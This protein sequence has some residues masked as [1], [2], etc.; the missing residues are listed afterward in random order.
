VNGE[1]RADDTAS[2]EEVG[3][4]RDELLDQLLDERA[5]LRALHE[6]AHSMDYG[7]EVGWVNAFS[8]DAVF[9]VF[10]AVEGTLIHR[11]E[12]H[13]DLAKYVAN[14]PKPPRFRKHIVVDPLI[15]VRGDEA[16]VRAYWVLLERH[17]ETGS[18]VLA[19]FGHYDDTFRKADGRWVIVDRQAS[20]E[21][22]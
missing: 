22:M 6:Y 13:G 9:N 10:R 4:T 20:V 18:P 5:I 21:A 1:G 7:D 14:Y 11:E 15:D 2:D 12:G 8:P 3:V 19:A 16:S 17:D